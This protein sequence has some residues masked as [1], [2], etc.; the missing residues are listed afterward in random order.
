MLAYL[1]LIRCRREFA[2]LC[3]LKSHCS[4]TNALPGNKEAWHLEGCAVWQTRLIMNEPILYN[5]EGEKCYKLEISMFFITGGNRMLLRLSLMLKL[6]VGCKD[7]LLLLAIAYFPLRVSF[8][9]DLQ[10]EKFSKFKLGR[11]ICTIWEWQLIIYLG[12]TDIVNGLHL[13]LKLS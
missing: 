9:R 3:I 8:S 12:C 10:T 13:H 6:A 7:P 4:Y 1:T 11:Y 2:D 5:Q